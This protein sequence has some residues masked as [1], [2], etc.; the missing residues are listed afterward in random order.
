MSVSFEYNLQ[1]S[2]SPHGMNNIETLSTFKYPL[3]PYYYFFLVFKF[4]DV[5]LGS[6]QGWL[7]RPCDTISTALYIHIKAHNSILQ[8]KKRQKSFVHINRANSRSKLKLT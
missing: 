3:Y 5:V 7:Y 1:K 6:W 4:T 2:Q 8:D